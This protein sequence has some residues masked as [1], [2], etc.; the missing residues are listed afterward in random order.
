MNPILLPIVAAVLLGIALWFRYYVATG[1]ESSRWF[2]YWLIA[3][4]M[5]AL[6]GAVSYWTVDPSISTSFFIAYRALLSITVFLLF[7]F[8]RSFS[9]K[10]DYTILFCSLPLQFDIAL[11]VVINSGL[12][13]K[14]GNSYVMNFNNAF[15]VIHISIFAFYALLTIYYF[16]MV[17]LDLRKAGKTREMKQ[18]M[19]FIL[20][21]V[22]MIF[23][24]MMEAQIRSW[25]KVDIPIGG[26][27][28]ILGAFIIVMALRE[29]ADEAT[30]E[31]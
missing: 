1:G 4:S 10:T 2:L 31:M 11:L 22:L 19:L 14:Q 25:L 28:I 20:A 13:K 27:G 12:L 7:L 29:T 21:L 15:A 23:F 18:V 16:V 9:L 8:A 17:Y 30:G 5:S 26:I 3:G 24:M 6:C